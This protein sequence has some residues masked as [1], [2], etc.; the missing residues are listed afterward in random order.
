[1]IK[2]YTHDDWPHHTFL[3]QISIGRCDIR[4]KVCIRPNLWNMHVCFTEA[5]H[6]TGQNRKL[7]FSLSHVSLWIGY[8]VNGMFRQQPRWNEIFAIILHLMKY[9]YVSIDSGES[10][11]ENE[12]EIGKKNP[13]WKF[14]LVIFVWYIIFKDKGRLCVVC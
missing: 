2:I 3:F 4:Q 6:W 8:L 1:M 13:Q 10:K 9:V 7:S 5:K 11:V 14:I 12:N